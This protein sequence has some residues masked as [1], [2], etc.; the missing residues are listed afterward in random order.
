MRPSAGA[1]RSPPQSKVTTTTPRN[2][3][4]ISR[5]LIILSIV[6][7]VILAITIV[8]VASTPQAVLFPRL[9]SF[10]VTRFSNTVCANKR[11]GFLC[12]TSGPHRRIFSSRTM[13][14]STGA[15]LP[16]ERE[17]RVA[18]LAVQRAAVLSKA[19]YNSKVKGTLE[20]DDNSPVTIADFGAQSLVFAS[21][22]KNF[23]DDNIIGEE[24]SADLRSNKELTGLVFKA[25]T[26]AIYSN[27]TGQSSSSS[28]T[29]SGPVPE[30]GTVSNETE[31]MDFIDKGRHTESGKGRVWAL[32]PIDGTKG[33]L[34]G[35]QYAIA[36]ALLVDGVVEVGVLGCPNLGEDG[37]V[38]VSAVRGQG[39]VVRPL[40]SDFS[41]LADPSRVTMKP[42]TTSSEAAFCEGVESGH[43]NHNLQG[44]IA[45]GLGITKDPVRYDS[46]VKYAALALGQA[47]IY[48]R[49][50]TSMKYEEKIWDH[51]AGSLVVEEAGGAVFDMYG[52]KLDFTTGRT[53]KRNKGVIVMPKGIA[54]DVVRVVSE[55]AIEVYGAKSVL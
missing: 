36:L 42:I 11:I 48:L 32:D 21:L 29:S 26:D 39:T 15:S 43:S 7:P 16:F 1:A 38:L 50:P 23:P 12:L 4:S 49:L 33:F 35:G 41:T 31:M 44:K 3:H 6:L 55:A 2:K 30:L 24:D 40:S 25:V 20:K 5:V 19:V 10:I 37:G 45:S 47:E 27:A 53:F 18:E 13:A 8:G 14:T 9:Q 22:D 46:Q 34:R 17:R 54:E 51:A 28:S 52:D